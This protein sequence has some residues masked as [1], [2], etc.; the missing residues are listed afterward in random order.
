MKTKFSPYSFR[1]LALLLALTPMN[2]A[3][4]SDRI[5]L[6]RST[7]VKITSLTPECQINHMIYGQMLEDCNDHIIYGGVVDTLGIVNKGVLQ[8]IRDLNVPV[9]RW[10]AGTSIYD[11]DWE[12][13]IGPKVLRKTQ[14][15]VIWHGKEYYTFGTDEFLHWCDSIGTQ[16]YIN[17]NMGNMMMPGSSLGDAMK[18][19]EYVNGDT[20]TPMGQLR[21]KNGH[22]KPY[23][24]KY[25]CIGNENYL[26]CP[27]PIH[28]RE[29]AL[30]YTRQ[31]ER[32]STALKGAW[33]NI[34]LLG[35]G[36]FADW[37]DTLLI[38]CGRNLDFLTQHFYMFS[39]IKD[40]KL[41]NPELTIFSP[42]RMEENL[43]TL[44]VHLEKMNR[45]LGRT[46]N[47]IRLSIDEWN[48]R[49]SVIR[50]GKRIF[51]RLDERRIYDVPSV[52]SF[53]NVL[54]RKSPMISMA[55]YIFPI[56]GHGL[57]RNEG[58]QDAY[59]TVLYDVFR[60]Y[61]QNMIGSRVG[62]SIEGPSIRLKTSDLKMEGDVD[63][64]VEKQ[65][66]QATYVDAVATVHDDTLNIALTNRSINSPQKVILQ[67]PDHYTPIEAWQ[68]YDPNINESSEFKSNKTRA[69]RIKVKRILTLPPCG[70][71]L[72]KCR[73]IN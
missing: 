35:V 16:P 65:T 37:N 8:F 46:R 66:M 11:Y 42:C 26:P 10:P 60:L 5:S 28:H 24:V 71:L 21:S 2:K 48:N 63:K 33:P 7:I 23:G 53:L 19:I 3:S 18:W 54:I 47:P 44:C 64:R 62:I 70:F 41:L 43:D 1:L 4:A 12:R 13:G 40:G 56:N 39:D 51:D 27:A 49:H 15:E 57:I 61:R 67:L 58:P 22:T 45:S 55:C 68:I 59:P 73:A 32:W 38:K 72:I 31:M 36:H 6:P 34:S 14:K 52:A 29:S 20:L 17:L 30:Q 9:M 69:R 50:D 25:W